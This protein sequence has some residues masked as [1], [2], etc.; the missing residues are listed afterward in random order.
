MYEVIANVATMVDAGEAETPAAAKRPLQAGRM[1]RR[2]GKAVSGIS[3][4]LKLSVV[5]TDGACADKMWN[6]STCSLTGSC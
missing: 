2:E 4:N 1:R 3:A 6:I 5:A